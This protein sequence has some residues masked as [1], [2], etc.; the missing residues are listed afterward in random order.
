MNCPLT[1]NLT[2]IKKLLCATTGLS[3]F[4]GGIYSTRYVNNWLNYLNKKQSMTYDNYIDQ[5]SIPYDNYTDQQS[6]TYDNHDISTINKYPKIIIGGFGSTSICFGYLGLLTG[7]N[8]INEIMV[9]TSCCNIIK[10]AVINPIYFTI[11]MSISLVSG[12]L[13]SFCYYKCYRCDNKV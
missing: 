4:G 13:G 12:M 10:S 7:K 8:F 11:F 1:Q 2:P 3:I 5:Q 6:M 9:A